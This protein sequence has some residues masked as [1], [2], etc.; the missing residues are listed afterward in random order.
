ML[1][2]WVTEVDPLS[3]I[4]RIVKEGLSD[5]ED[6]DD[7]LDDFEEDESS[8]ASTSTNATTTDQGVTSSSVSS[9]HS[10]SHPNAH[11]HPCGNKPTCEE[12]NGKECAKECSDKHCGEGGKNHSCLCCYCEMFGHGGPSAAPVSKNYPEMRERLRL[13]LSKKK[14]SKP[15]P[16]HETKIQEEGSI[17]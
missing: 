1:I 16:H 9:K 3:F 6:D 7:D 2:H 15:S 13:L 5:E 10:H 12:K 4:L 14:K 8:Q 11:H 17:Q